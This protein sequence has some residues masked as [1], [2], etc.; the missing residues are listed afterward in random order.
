MLPVIKFRYTGLY[1]CFKSVRYETGYPA[2]EFTAWN[3][4]ARKQEEKYV[5]E[6]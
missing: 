5:M 2:A 4:C 3:S 6:S 1:K